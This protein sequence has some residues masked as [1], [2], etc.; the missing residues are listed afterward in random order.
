MSA[1]N[2]NKIIDTGY[3]YCFKENGEDIEISYCNPRAQE[4]RERIT[5]LTTCG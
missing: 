5:N 2:T 3:S 1:Q 4:I